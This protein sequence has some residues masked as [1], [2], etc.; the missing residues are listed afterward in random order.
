MKLKIL[1]CLICLPT[2]VL[3]QWDLKPLVFQPVHKDYVWRFDSSNVFH[4]F[5]ASK[6]RDYRIDSLIYKAELADSLCKDITILSFKAEKYLLLLQEAYLELR[7]LK[8]DSLANRLE[9]VAFDSR[10]RSCK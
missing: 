5:S 8:S 6:H 1:V 2:L 3:A 9:F 4:F 10:F 7:R